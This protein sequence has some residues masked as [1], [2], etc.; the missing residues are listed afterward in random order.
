MSMLCMASPMLGRRR[1]GNL[2][3]VNTVLV[4]YQQASNVD[5]PNRTFP[6]RLRGMTSLTGQVVS[7]GQGGQE[8]SARATLLHFIEF[9]IMYIM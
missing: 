8:R 2:I 9:R 5:T 6:S 1:A 7:M 3:P 4:R